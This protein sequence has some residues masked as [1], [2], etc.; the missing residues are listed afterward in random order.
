VGWNRFQSLSREQTRAPA[1]L[2]GP[3]PRSRV[4]SGAVPL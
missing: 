4:D 3:F 1:Q 2:A